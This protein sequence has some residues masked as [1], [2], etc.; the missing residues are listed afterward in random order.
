[1]F[2]LFRPPPAAPLPAF[3][4]FGSVF[5]LLSCLLLLSHTHLTVPFFLI[6]LLLIYLLPLFFTFQCKAQ[7]MAYIPTAL[8]Q[9]GETILPCQES[10]FINV[11]SLMKDGTLDKVTL[12]VWR[13]A[14]RNESA[15]HRDAALHQRINLFNRVYKDDHCLVHPCCRVH[16]AVADSLT[17]CQAAALH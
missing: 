5:L 1:M 17:H 14:T 6:C 7:V 15:I 16:A 13:A 4:F 10:S 12:A 2:P 3:F 8:F 9:M 11:S